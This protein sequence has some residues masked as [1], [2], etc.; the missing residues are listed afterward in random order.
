MLSAS[1]SM[2][3]PAADAAAGSIRPESGRELPRTRSDVS[4]ENGELVVKI[5]ASDTSAMRAAL[6]SYLECIV[7][8][9]NVQHIAGVKE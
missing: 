1:L 9:Q 2:S 4:F 7:V 6:N 3:G 8:V 5:T